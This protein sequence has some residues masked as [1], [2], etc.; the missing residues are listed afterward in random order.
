VLDVVGS[1]ARHDLINVP[2]LLGLPLTA[3]DNGVST[4]EAV[5]A[6]AEAAEAQERQRI[7]G[8]LEAQEVDLLRQP[9]VQEQVP[10]RAATTIRL[11]WLTVD[12]FYVLPLGAPGWLVLSPD[13]E[14]E[15]WSVSVLAKSGARQI[16]HEGLSLPYAQGTGEDYTHNAGAGGLTNPRAVWRQ[17]AA[18]DKQR[19]KLR[20]GSG[21]ELTCGE[22]SDRITSAEMQVTA[23]HANPRFPHPVW[24]G[25]DEEP[26]GLSEEEREEQI[27][28]MTA[29]FAAH[30]QNPGES[31]AEWEASGKSLSPG[32]YPEYGTWPTEEALEKRFPDVDEDLRDEAVERLEEGGIKDWVRLTDIE[33]EAE[34][35]ERWEDKSPPY[36]TLVVHCVGKTD[37]AL[38]VSLDNTGE[39]VWVPVAQIRAGGDVC[40]P[41]DFGELRIRTTF[42]KQLRSQVTSGESAGATG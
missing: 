5:A 4:T 39:K 23:V 24:A 28:E 1:T 2:S 35:F 17:R 30:F 8:E 16:L 6:I 18:S 26:P 34:Y 25:G 22:A 21:V 14:E 9:R 27:E 20:V 19:W 31:E 42:A 7:E 11:H 10:L 13:L 36:T 12:R 3:L 38:L 37:E 32:S 33:S 41:G 29:W 15:K 40:C